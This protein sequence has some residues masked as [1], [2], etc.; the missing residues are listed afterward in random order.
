MYATQPVQNPV[1][2]EALKLSG[3]SG[4]AIFNDQV[5]INIDAIVSNR[6][7]D[8]ISGTLAIELWALKQPYYGGDFAGECLAATTIGEILGQHYLQ[9]CQY[10]LNFKEP[11]VG[12][13]YLCLMLREWTANGYV[14]RDQVNFDQP[15]TVSWKPE[16]IKNTPD[17]VVS[18]P[19]AETV[20]TDHL[21]EDK[22]EV[23]A[24]TAATAASGELTGEKIDLQ[25]A[26]KLTA[27]LSDS[28]V[29]LN[30]ASVEDMAR[31]KFISRKLAKQIFNNRPFAT[32]DELL[33]V[34]GMGEKLLA[35]VRESIKL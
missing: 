16:L 31:I 22:V 7:A 21:T 27:E 30:Q 32:F 10:L 2:P 19:V 33:Q 14:T 29:S 34:K 11:G 15:Y 4:Y 26:D 28:R 20:S 9:N 18:M 35:R 3:T 1:S 6:F 25:N 23:I 13:W 17:N 8:D 12:S 5:T 24:D